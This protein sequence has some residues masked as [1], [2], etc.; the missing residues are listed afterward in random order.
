M[1]YGE[2]LYYLL[3]QLPMFQRVGAAAY[4]KDLG[5]ITSLCDILGNPQIDLKCIHVAGTN[6]KGSVVHLLSSVL[7]EQGYKVGTFV[8]PH[9]KD[10]RERIKINGQY[11]SK[12][13]VTKF[14]SKHIQ[15]FKKVDASFF[16]ITTAM[17]FAYF[18][19]KKVDF[20]VIET[21]MGGRLD[22]TNI[23]QP[24]LSVITNISFDHQQFLGKTLAKIAKEKAGIIKRNVPVVIGETVKETK[25]VFIQ[26]AK[27]AG[28]DIY[29]A[30]KK[31]LDFKMKMQGAY[32]EKNMATV[33]K[34]I[35]VLQ[36]GGIKISKQSIRKGIENV[37]MNT[38]FIGRWMIISQ[39]PMVI[40]DSA[41]NE[42]GL[43]VVA[44]EIK[45]LV[46][47]TQSAQVHFVYGTVNDKDISRCLSVLPKSAKYY[48][49]KANIPR[50]RNADELKQEAM[51]YKLKGQTYPSVKKAYKAALGNA[52]KKDLVI[53]AGSVFVV[54]EVL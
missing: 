8:S 21:G 10:Y 1:T 53:V 41:H 14:V 44:K 25:P 50:G 29:F 16:E 46:A 43:R 33:L 24:I 13:Y 26:K 42:A 11:I 31:M 23:I 48:F 40:L 19:E 15:S 51:K 47:R 20:V 37:S 38:S 30:E 34:A 35:E 49:C 54:A 36:K 32:Q 52:N 5:N 6:G 22:S 39:K 45:Q 28:S 3:E 4:R 12:D 18:K 17:A 2:T 7:Q 27:A 9:Y